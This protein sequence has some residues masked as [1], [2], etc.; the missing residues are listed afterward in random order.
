[1]VLLEVLPLTPNDKVDRK[2]LPAPDLTPTT[3]SRAAATP[4][5]VLLAGLFAQIL[6]L[7][8]VGMED[9]FFELGGH[10]LLAVQLAGRIRTDLGAEL[11]IRD[12]FEAPSITA[13]LARMDRGRVGGEFDVLLPLRTSGDLPPLFCIHPGFGVSWSYIGLAAHIPAGRPLYALQARSLSQT[14]GLPGCVDE[15]AADYLEQIRSVQPSG[16][17]YLLGWSFGGVVAHAIASR[18]QAQGEQVDLLALLDS[19]PGAV[20]AQEDQLTDSQVAQFIDTT[21]GIP[22]QLGDSDITAIVETFAR[23]GM[24]M[25]DFIPGTFNGD[26]LFFT[27][28]QG[29]S[30]QEHT[31]DMWRTHVTGRVI[32]ADIACTHHDMTRPSALAEIGTAVAA[33]MQDAVTIND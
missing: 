4:D 9:S 5:E 19:Y 3:A 18:L 25:Q 32:N 15:M 28:V 10:S 21:P 22:T 11:S 2:A 8:D 30:G 6:G 7:P 20:V 29:R 16:P 31:S 14:Q 17:Y 1:V 27:A 24:L 13:L 12:I 26:L 33:A 23:N